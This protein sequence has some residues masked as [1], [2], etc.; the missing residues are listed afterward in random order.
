M[1]LADLCKITQTDCAVANRF[2]QYWRAQTP[3]Q[4]EC[5]Q[6]YDVKTGHI[7]GCDDYAMVPKD[8]GGKNTTP[9]I[10]LAEIKQ[11]AAA[12]Y[13]TDYE[14]QEY[15]IRQQTAAYIA[16]ENFVSPQVPDD[17]LRQIKTLALSKY[18][19]DYEMQEYKMKQQGEAYIKINNYS[20]PSIPDNVISQIM[21]EAKTKYPTDYEMQEYKIRQQAEAYSRIK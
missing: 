6:H 3:A 10:P 9:S 11:R 1:P 18:P 17:I 16:V 4:A 15:K 13:P 2:E 5:K 20:N 12:K 19:D 7:S 14:M 21:I 8:P